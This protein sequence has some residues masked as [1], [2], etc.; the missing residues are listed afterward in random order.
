MFQYRSNQFDPRL[1]AIAGHLRAIEKELSILGR[2]AG[3]GAADRASA[4]GDQITDLLGPIL[5]DIG[6]R[7]RR[8]Q[9]VAVDE[10]ANLGNDAV[11]F[12]AKM[13]NDAIGRI[14]D[15]AKQRPLFTLAVAIGIGVLIGFAGRRNQ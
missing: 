6:D 11:R 4:A 10:A 9:R 13:G 15:Q 3:Q 1:T 7:F 12:G 5:S 8:G 2:R 14:A